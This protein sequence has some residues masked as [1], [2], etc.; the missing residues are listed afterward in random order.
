VAVWGHDELTGEAEVRPDGYLTMPLVGAVAV[1]GLTPE[2]TATLV[3]ERLTPFLKEPRVTAAVKEFRR[4]AVQVAGQVKS[5]GLY[6][7]RPPVR[8]SDALAAAGGPLPEADLARISRLPRAGSPAVLD[9]SGPYWRGEAAEDPE[10]ADGD[11]LFLPELRKLT[12][13]GQVRNPGQLAVRPGDGLLGLLARA[14]GATERASLEAVRLYRGG[15]LE[16]PDSV[17]LGRDHLFF[18]G[19]VRT[20]PAVA[21]G[22]VVYVPETRRVD[23][24][25]VL[26]VLTCL[27]LVRDVFK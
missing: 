14:G 8:L 3:A 18:E 10:L 21:P 2:E 12:V 7:L 5:P 16:Q 4:A 25:K 9:F 22:D 6:R 20:N 15:R 11:R 19:D 17:A 27:N 13:L 1:A 24:A 26:T 23:W